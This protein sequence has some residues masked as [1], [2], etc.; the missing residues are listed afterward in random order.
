MVI[1]LLR[2]EAGV[3]L[4]TSATSL[5]LLHHQVILLCLEQRSLLRYSVLVLVAKLWYQSLGDHGTFS[6]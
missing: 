3:R 2:F 4:K 6:Y 5:E 1:C